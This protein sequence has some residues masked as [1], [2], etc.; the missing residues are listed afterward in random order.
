MAKKSR[1][2]K[3]KGTPPRLSEAQR[4]QPSQTA[5]QEARPEE[6]SAE[7]E[8]MRKS[9]EPDFADEY[10]YV[11]EDL[12]RIGILAAAMLGG[13]VALYFII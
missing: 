1:R 2:V 9:E 11:M 7:V 12:R 5:I 13:L 3:K 4:I 10:R 6:D 8:V